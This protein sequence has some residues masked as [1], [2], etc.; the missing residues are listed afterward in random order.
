M[1][2]QDREVNNIPTLAG[3]DLYSTKAHK[4]VGEEK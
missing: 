2:T 3:W 4:A 1:T